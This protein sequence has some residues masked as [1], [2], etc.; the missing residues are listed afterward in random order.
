MHFANFYGIPSKALLVI[1]K[2]FTV[3]ASTG[4]NLMASKPFVNSRLICDYCRKLSVLILWGSY[5]IVRRHSSM[6]KMNCFSYTGPE[7]TIG[8]D[9]FTHKF[10]ISQSN[11]QP[12]WDTERINSFK[13]IKCTRCFEFSDSVSY[14]TLIKFSMQILALISWLGPVWL[15][16]FKNSKF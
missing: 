1:I 15:M 14:P 2:N 10:G 8:L 5:P 4:Q 12:P 6:K 9:V 7:R 13:K 3:S 11:S 16:E